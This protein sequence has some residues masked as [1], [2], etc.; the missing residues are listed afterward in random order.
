M[1][2]LF[3]VF[4]RT[5]QT[6][7]PKEVAKSNLLTFG[8]SGALRHRQFTNIRACRSS[9]VFWPGVAHVGSVQP[10]WRDHGERTKTWIP[11]RESIA[12]I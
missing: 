4:Y 5:P 1:V 8:H 10:L 12:K 7:D 6:R 11:A 3:W 2:F 9:K